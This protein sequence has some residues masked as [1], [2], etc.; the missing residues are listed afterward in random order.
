[1]WE[2]EGLSLELAKSRSV[3]FGL[4]VFDKVHPKH[5][6]SLVETAVVLTQLGITCGHSQAVGQPHHRA[7]NGIVTAFLASPFTDLIFID[8]D[9]SWNP[10]DVVRLLASPHEVVA[11]VG[12]KRA[13]RDDND[14]KSWCFEILEDEAPVRAGA[15]S[16]AHVG[17]GFM[18]ISRSA[19]GLLAAAR[20]E[21]LRDVKDRKP[22]WRFFF[23][24]DDGVT[25]HGEDVTFCREYRKVGGSIWADLGITLN[26]YGDC[27]YSGSVLSLFE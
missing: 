2:A 6:A 5:V 17:T 16:V 18:R 23:W 13:V 14:P 20:P 21:Y 15:I 7:R 19:L 26:H 12:R 1:M 9:M 4:P 22:Y 10:W 3:C 24:D 8:A 25:E 27:T 11:G